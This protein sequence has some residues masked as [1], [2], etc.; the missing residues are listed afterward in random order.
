M[1]TIVNYDREARNLSLSKGQGS[2]TP[3]LAEQRCESL[4]P[5]LAHKRQRL[6]SLTPVTA[7][8]PDLIVK[9]QRCQLQ[10]IT[11]FITGNFLVESS[12]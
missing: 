4:T 1:V 10:L 5:W 6:A 12:F 8:L 2:L 7:S 3:C 9:S 11:D